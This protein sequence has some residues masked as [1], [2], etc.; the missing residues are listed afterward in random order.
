MTPKDLAASVHARL[1]NRAREMA[2]PFQELLEYYGME[3]FLYRL[4]RS[5]HGKH[6]VL[7]GALMLRVWDAPIARPTRDIDLLGRLNNAP[8]NLARVVREVCDVDVADDGL[9]FK[10]STV[11]AVRIKEDA[12]YEGVRIRLQGLL[13]KA[14]VP[15]QIDVGFGDVVVPAPADISYPTLLDFPAPKL[16]G[17]PR[18]SVVAEKFEAMVKLGSLNSRMKDFYDVWLMS[19]RFDFDGV[20]LAAAVKA[21]FEHRKTPLE[22]QPIALTPEFSESTAPAGLWTAFV[23]RGRFTAV[24]D[25]FAEVVSALADFLSPVA[26]SARAGETF[27]KA[28]KPS[29]PWSQ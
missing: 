12:D 19:R 25:R 7:K 22:P 3:R 6:F 20:S 28:W 8:D 18:E 4:S 14:R 1:A 13:G 16:K 2:R 24:P 23:R 11:E 10:S 21:T 15:M 27:H 29:G 9:V 17:Y 5:A 26:R